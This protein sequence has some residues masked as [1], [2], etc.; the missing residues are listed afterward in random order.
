MSYG[1]MR[2][3]WIL[4]S[5]SMLSIHACI[6]IYIYI[7]RHPQTYCFVVS[8]LFSVAKHV[9]RLKLESKPTQLYVR[10]CIIPLSPQANHISSRIIRHYVVAFLCLHFCLIRYQ[11]VQ[12][13]RRA[14]H[15]ASGSRQSDAPSRGLSTLANRV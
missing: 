1:G 3:K 14:L 4:S 9:G 2:D 7:Y 10:L 13:I 5:S 8:R 15:Y 6:L 11:S 12:F